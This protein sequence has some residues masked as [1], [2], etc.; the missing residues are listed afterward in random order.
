VLEAFFDHFGP[1]RVVL[2]KRNPTALAII[3]FHIYWCIFPELLI[4]LA[5]DFDG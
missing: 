2:K 5:V 4:V 1:R 3:V